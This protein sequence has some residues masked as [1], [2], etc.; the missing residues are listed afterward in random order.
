MKFKLNEPIDHFTNMGIA[1]DV[2][3]RVCERER[4]RGVGGEFFPAY[5]LV[6]GWHLGEGKQDFFL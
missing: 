6:G 2:Q 3:Q 1:I 5:S 4:E